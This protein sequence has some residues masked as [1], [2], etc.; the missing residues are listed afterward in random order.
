MSFNR[1]ITRNFNAN[2]TNRIRYDDDDFLCRIYRFDKTYEK[3]YTVYNGTLSVINGNQKSFNGYGCYRSKNEN[4]LVVTFKYNAKETSSNYRIEMLYGN[5][6]KKTESSKKD[7]TLEASADITINGEKVKNSMAM[8]STDVN[9]NRHY[10][11]CTLKKGENIIQYSLSSNT[12]F[13][14]ACVKK[15]DIWEAKRHNNS[16]DKL[17]MIK[18]TVEHT[19]D[20]KINT[21]SAEFMYHHGLDELLEPTDS[22][23]NRSGLVFD[24]RDEINLY[25][26]DTNGELEQVFGGYISTATVDDDLT[27]MTLECADRLI[28]FDRRY[29]LS[30]I[31]MN[32]YT[33][34]QDKTD[35]SS[36]GDYLKH[37]NNYSDS[38]KFLIN[39]VELY[40]NTNVRVSKPLIKRN[41]QKLVTYRKG[42]YEKVTPK[43]MNISVN[44]GSITLRNGA[45]T[46]K[47][48]SVVI[49]DDKTAN[50]TVNLNQYPNL[51][52]HYGLGE[53]RWEKKI[54]EVKE[55][56]VLG[57][58]V[59]N[60]NWVKRANQITKATGNDAIKPIWR[61][62]ANFHQSKKSDFYQSAD[63]TWKS[64]SG[65]CCCKTECMLK[66]LNAKGVTDLK[67]VHCYTSPTRGHVFAKVN[68]FYVDPSTSSEARGWH[69]YLKGFGR[70]TKVTDYPQ[71]PF[72]K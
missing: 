10:Q 9:F 7:S 21:M 57:S 2:K 42:A 50:A 69:N 71:K 29:C 8:I 16:D 48:Q 18:A 1:H 3:Y 60:S 68:G 37:Y 61:Y 12:L 47:A 33:N 23:A 30:E 53:N 11:Y 35:Y 40:L 70:I 67:Y 36:R 34:K 25:V 58:T 43:N 6:H 13:I 72:G 20:F 38:L 63:K 19:K 55:V 54:E 64:K 26:K 28:D 44:K 59:T 4:K 41:N 56:E 14:G 45:D 62:V 5:T 22:R 46:L 49:F 52:F 39:N 17:T 15:Y 65:N 31:Y 51:Y 27:K 32:G 24:Y 66:L